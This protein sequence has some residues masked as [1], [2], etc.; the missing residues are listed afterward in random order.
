MYKRGLINGLILILGGYALSLVLDTTVM[1][2]VVYLG[3]IYLVVSS[4][5]WEK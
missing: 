5:T 4:H 1:E 2:S 3:V